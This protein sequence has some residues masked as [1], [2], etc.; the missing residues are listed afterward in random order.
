M[1]IFFFLLSKLLTLCVRYFFLRHLLCNP[2]WPQ[3]E[4]PPA[5]VS[6]MLEITGMC[7]HAGYLL[8]LCCRYSFPFLF[9]PFLFSSLLFFS[10]LSY[11][12]NIPNEKC[13]FFRKSI[14]WFLLKH[15]FVGSWNPRK[16]RTLTFKLNIY[17]SF[18]TL[19]LI[20]NR[21]KSVSY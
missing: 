14:N 3:S 6:Y 11:H 1:H 8:C 20:S 2:G 9:L 18:F 21:K 13:P 19:Q 17:F 15:T 10:F 12:F 7:Y 4:K 5:R 16:H